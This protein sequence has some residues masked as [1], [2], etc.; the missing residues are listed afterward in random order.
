MIKRQ[1]TQLDLDNDKR[2][3]SNKN[4]DEIKNKNENAKIRVHWII[5]K[6]TSKGRDNNRATRFT[7]N[8]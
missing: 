7:D 5:I 6:M 1:Y 2:Q 4:C 8:G 3:N